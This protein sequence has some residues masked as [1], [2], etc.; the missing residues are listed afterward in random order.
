MDIEDML[1]RVNLLGPSIIVTFV[2][3]REYLQR[4]VVIWIIVRLGR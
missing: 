2:P 1:P 4:G 3:P